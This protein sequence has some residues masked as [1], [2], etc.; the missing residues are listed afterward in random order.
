MPISTITADSQIPEFGTGVFINRSPPMNTVRGRGNLVVGIICAFPWGDAETWVT[1]DDDTDLLESFI[2]FGWGGDDAEDMFGLPWGPIRVWNVRGSGNAAATRTFDDASTG[3]SLTITARKT[4]SAGN[5]ILITITANATTSSS[6]DVRVYVVDPSGGVMWD[7]T[8]LAVQTSDGTVTDPGDPW[9]TMSKASGAS[10]QAA[11]ISA[12]A[13]SGGSEGT[14]AASDYRQAMDAAGPDAGVDILVC[15][16]LDTS[17][18]TG[19]R[20]TMATWAA[21]SIAESVVCAILPTPAGE[22]VSTA[23]T[24]IASYRHRKLRALYPRIQR[25]YTYSYRGYSRTA[26]ATMDGAAVLACIIQRAGPTASA[27]MQSVLNISDDAVASILDLE[28][29]YGGISNGSQNSLMAAGINGWWK[30]RAAGRF[31]PLHGV[32]TYLDSSS[33]PAR[34]LDER[35][36]HYVSNA[37]AEALERISGLPLDVDLADRRLGPTTQAAIT[38][39]TAF[40]EGLLNQSLIVAGNNSNGTTSPAYTIDP[41]GMASSQNLGNNRWDIGLAYRQT[42]TAERVVLRITAGTNVDITRL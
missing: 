15:V 22:S 32:T 12:A 24:N 20:A 18:V 6:R 2:P 23:I 21:S 36:Y 42:P 17:L 37:I 13:L 8:Y 31:V 34:D 14:L 30:N 19:V 35:F 29:G 25:S 41:F 10:A 28:S 1:P 38:A 33:R 7:E 16:G 39:I 40:M 5:R 9:V 11:A 27:F 26:T 3:D 4:G